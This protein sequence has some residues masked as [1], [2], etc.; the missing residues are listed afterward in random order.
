M[1]LG[2]E[3]DPVVARLA[4]LIECKRS[5]SPYVFFRSATDRR[6][7]DFPA[8]YGLEKA[9]I[10][11]AVDGQGSSN[12]FA[13][14]A[15]GLD[16]MKFV[17]SGPPMV[18]TFAKTELKG[19]KATLSGE[20]VY[21]GILMP[22][23]GAMKQA[24]SFVLGWHSGGKKYPAVTLGVCVLDAPMLLADARKRPHD[25]TL[26][27]WVRIARQE[28]VT[29]AH[30]GSGKVRFYAFDIVHLDF[31][32]KFLDDYLLPFANEYG[33]RVKQMLGVIKRGSG[34]VQSN[35]WRWSDIK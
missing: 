18:S 13:T 35:D 14:K 9:G 30:P 26:T 25:L 5:G 23:I 1:Q 6:S 12:A 3:T 15:F 21:S 33:E 11:I 10:D 19:E 34:T 29:D 17:L 31:F 27:P 2:Q 8:V 20:D 16:E 28:I 22:L 24:S 32:R 7:P 4:I